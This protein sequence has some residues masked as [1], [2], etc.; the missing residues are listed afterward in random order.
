LR[1]KLKA[2]LNHGPSEYIR[3]FRLKK[4]PEK[5]VAGVQIQLAA[6]DAGFASYSTFIASFKARY[7]MSPSEYLSRLT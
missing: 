7:G 2:L 4:A 6:L 1:R 5:M 3:A